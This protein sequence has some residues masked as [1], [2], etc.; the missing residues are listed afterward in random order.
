MTFKLNRCQLVGNKK[1][2]IQ[3]YFRYTRKLTEMLE[4]S[5]VKRNTDVISCN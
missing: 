2:M 3:Q 1:H 4:K 5:E